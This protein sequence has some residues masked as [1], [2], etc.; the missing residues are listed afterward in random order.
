MRN[1]T[2]TP[3][4]NWFFPRWQNPSAA[5]SSLIKSLV[6]PR[7]WE[8]SDDMSEDNGHMHGLY[9]IYYACTDIYDYSALCCLHLQGVGRYIKRS[10]ELYIISYR[11]LLKCVLLLLLHT[12]NMWANEISFDFYYHFFRSEIVLIEYFKVI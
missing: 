4:S 9:C 8:I 10:Y 1:V 11:L 7:E 6:W 2:L 12:F 3:R 5:F